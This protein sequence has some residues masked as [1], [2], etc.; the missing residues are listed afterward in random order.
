MKKDGKEKMTNLLIKLWIKNSD[1]IQDSAVREQYGVLSSCV[2]AACNIFL[3]LVKFFIGTVSHS[4]AITGD[5]FNNLSDVGSSIVTFIGFKMASQPADEDHPFGHG[6]IEYISGLVIAFFILMVG[7]E[8]LKTS[9]DK[10]FHPGETQFSFIA[11]FI[12]ILSIL[13]KFWMSRFNRSL[14]NKIGSQAMK[15]AATDSLNDCISTGATTIG[16]I[17]AFFL[18]FQIDGY[19]GIMVGVF[20]LYSGYGIA[21]ETISPLLGNSPSPELTEKVKSILM[22]YSIISGVHDLI[23]HD[24]GPNRMMGSAHVE[25]PKNCDILL[26][27]DSI[28]NAEKQIQRELKIPFVIHLDPVATEDEETKEAKKMIEKIVTQIDEKMTIHDF[29]VISGNTHTNFIF[30]LVIPYENKKTNKEI[31][32]MIDEKIAKEGQNYYTV[33]TFDRSFI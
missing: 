3:F 24:Y 19:L 29:R 12:L 26:A 10:I 4:I 6:R 22:S 14:G 17:V 28:D 13:I 27:H 5:A 18:P 25:V 30:D 33:I 9:V 16:V 1:Q 11:I 23:I 20:I 32:K 2:G 31:K 7:V 8:I 15:A 21:K